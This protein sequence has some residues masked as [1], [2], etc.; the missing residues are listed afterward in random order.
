MLRSHIILTIYICQRFYVR[1]TLDWKNFFGAK[2]IAGMIPDLV[3]NLKIPLKNFRTDQK[4]TDIFK[5]ALNN[6]KKKQFRN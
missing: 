2:P 4:N 3:F 6:Q 1:D 5:K